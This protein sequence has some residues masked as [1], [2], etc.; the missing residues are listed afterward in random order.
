MCLYIIGADGVIRAAEVH[1]AA[2]ILEQEL[3]S[4]PEL[5]Q[6]FHD[7]VS[8]GAQA[9]SLALE[10]LNLYEPIA[11][12][13]IL[14]AGLEIASAD[15][16]FC[17][18]EQ[19]R[20][21]ELGFLI[22]CDPFAVDAL[23]RAKLQSLEEDSKLLQR[24]YLGLGVSP[25]TPIEQIEQAYLG[26]RQ[27][28][29]SSN[30]EVLGPDFVSLG[31]SRLAAIESYWDCIQRHRDRERLFAGP[32]QDLEDSETDQVPPGRPPAQPD[33]FMQ[34][35]ID[36]QV[37]ELLA[38]SYRVAISWNAQ[39]RTGLEMMVQNRLKGMSQKTFDRLKAVIELDRGVVAN[40]FISWSLDWAATCEKVHGVLELFD[41]GSVLTL[42]HLERLA[43]SPPARFREH[44]RVAIASFLEQLAEASGTVWR[45]SNVESPTEGHSTSRLP[46]F[47]VAD[48]SPTFITHW[49][50]L[51]K[52]RHW[53]I[54]D[55]RFGLTGAE[56]RILEDIGQELGL[57]RERIRQIETRALRLVHSNLI[58]AN[59]DNELIKVILA[60]FGDQNVTVLSSS[61]L[62]ELLMSD[63]GLSIGQDLPVTNFLLWLHEVYQFEGMDSRL[64]EKFYFRGLSNKQ[65]LSVLA[66]LKSIFH[67]TLEAVY[68]L[69]QVGDLIENETGLTLPD[70]VLAQ[71]LQ[72]QLQVEMKA[73]DAYA[74]SFAFL[75]RKEQVFRALR[76]LGEPTHY[77]AIVG[78]L[79]ARLGNS[80]ELNVRSMANYLVGD[81]RVRPLGRSGYWGLLEWGVEERPIR[82]LMVEVLQRAGSPLD[83]ESIYNAIANMRPVARKS[84]DMY[85]ASA[86]QLF[87]RYGL[88]EWGLSSWEEDPNFQS[89]LEQK[90]KALILEF[91]GDD[92]GREVLLS[93]LARFVHARTSIPLR[94]C[95]AMLSWFP[96]LQ[97]DRRGWELAR[98]RF[99]D[100][101]RDLTANRQR[102]KPTQQMVF[103]Q[104]LCEE[105]FRDLPDQALP[106][107][108]IV[109][110]AEN[111]L[112]F[113]SAT[114]YTLI[115]NS[116]Y[117]EKY[118][119]ADVR[120]GRFS[121]EHSPSL[122]QGLFS[123]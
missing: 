77:E 63:P 50:G 89:N 83:A 84:I 79:Q 72:L 45:R 47:S 71:L 97:I 105:L 15:G 44:N 60:P 37:L 32:L 91:L 46:Q 86:D 98:C 112:G 90:F 23:I 5:V 85:L 34:L 30:L 82:D 103:D 93:E 66:C 76:D 114:T 68:T 110:A 51:L 101:P 52:P 48:F 10:S 41:E 67:E 100:T 102:R 26:F 61:Q 116:E 109:R 59:S 49:Q 29:S 120:M 94:S 33:D 64:R 57:T 22:A 92:P 62:W 58:S 39:D 113:P 19:C 87:T 73:E 74:T 7:R 11:K 81:D 65:L 20:I 78:A 4:P 96:Y 3:G 35:P 75:A 9:D 18:Q 106:L 16:E 69:S 117:L 43:Q 28:Y 36:L 24:A 6:K 80:E 2:L 104:F 53:F 55:A 54:L 70:Q 88:D 115:T 119:D 118:D 38:H 107:K 122:D 12:D 111:L 121:R 1:K 31:L 108:D 42:Q 14:R 27:R 40:T 13:L 123:T 8:Q 56:P 95:R 25:D 21:I 99:L 17:R